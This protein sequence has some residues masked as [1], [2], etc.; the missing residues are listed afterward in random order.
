MQRPHFTIKVQRRDDQWVVI[1]GMKESVGATV[2]EAI[3]GLET[4]G[5]LK[6]RCF[7]V[8]TQETNLLSTL[9]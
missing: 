3:Q 6:Y 9:G 2:L 4:D 8:D 7:Q 5:T 1:I